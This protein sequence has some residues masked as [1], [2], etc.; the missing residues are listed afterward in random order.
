MTTDASTVLSP[1]SVPAP[2]H[3]A[4][5]AF[6]PCSDALTRLEFERCAAAHRA[7]L[8][9]FAFWFTRDPFIAE[10]AVQEALL[11]AWQSWRALR[12]KSTAKYGLLTIVRR[13]CAR[14]YE[15]KRDPTSDIDE[16]SAAEQYLI[17]VGD[18]TELHDIRRALLRLDD[19]YREPLVLQVLM[20]HS[21]EEIA[22]I[23]GVTR[24]AV[25]T[26]LCRARQKLAEQI[27]E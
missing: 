26:R 18:E 27:I 16:L 3:P 17:A 2:E 21:T 25:L 15:R 4:F 9:R 19:A 6:A 24:G 10:D 11:R 5:E 14:M 20:G 1:E 23:M 8:Y 22:Q 7:D 13:E 12:D